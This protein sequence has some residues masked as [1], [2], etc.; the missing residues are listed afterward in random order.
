MLCYLGRE[1]TGGTV[2]PGLSQFLTIVNNPPVSEPFICKLTHAEPAP[3]PPP[4]SVPHTQSHYPPP[5]PDR[6]V[7]PEPGTRQP[8][9]TLVSKSPL[10]AFFKLTNP[11]FAYLASPLPVPS[12]ESHNKGSWA[13]FLSTPSASQLTPVPPPAA[14][15]AH[16]PLLLESVSRTEHV[17]KAIVSGLHTYIII[18]H[19]LT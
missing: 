13:H 16:W 3:Q 4:L 8:G 2:P 1:G 12:L 9:T 10:K 17:F 19:I 15:T 18:K 5:P 6:P 14:C 7:T 11:K